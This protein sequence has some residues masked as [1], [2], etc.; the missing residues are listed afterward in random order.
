MERNSKIISKY[1][2]I[3][4]S[5]E[6]RYMIEELPIQGLRETQIGDFIYAGHGYT[7]IGTKVFLTVIKIQLKNNEPVV[8]IVIP[9]AKISLSCPFN[10]D[11][12]KRSFDNAIK[13]KLN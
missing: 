13:I 10:M 8:S 11:R 7:E 5:D 3:R 2:R 1:Y 4:M 6:I 12:I 9:N